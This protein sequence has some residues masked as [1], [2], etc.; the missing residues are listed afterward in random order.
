VLL[1]SDYIIRP[2][3]HYNSVEADVKQYIQLAS[4]DIRVPGAV[5]RTMIAQRPYAFE[6][7]RG[8]RFRCTSKTGHALPR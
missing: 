4:D 1:V 7:C 6:G 3:L 8:L 5:R 2:Q